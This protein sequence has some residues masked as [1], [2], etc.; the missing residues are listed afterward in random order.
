MCYN[1]CNRYIIPQKK[2]ERQYMT[3]IF[4]IRHGEAE[5][6][7]YRR[8]QG[9]GDVLLTRNG[10]RQASFL[11]PRFAE[12]PL[13][14]VYSS[15]LK[16]AMATA[17]AAGAGRGLAPIPEPRLREMGFGVWEGKTWGEINRLW[18]EEKRFFLTDPEK[19]TVPGMES[20]RAVAERYYA[21][22]AEIARRHEGGCAAAAGHGMAIRLLAADLR[23]VPFSRIQEV[24]LCSNTA[25]TTLV[26]DGETFRIE[27]YNDTSHLPE[28]PMAPIRA[29]PGRGEPGWDLWFTPYEVDTGRDRYVRCYQDAWRQA[30]GSLE[31]FQASACWL[32][33]LRYRQE[34]PAAVTE[35]RRGEDFAGVLTLDTR[36]GA[37]KG[38]GWIAFF[39]I[40]PEL[41]RHGC[42]MQ[43]L[44]EAV[45]RF[46]ALG[47]R[48]VRLSVAP[49]NPAR[50]FYE[51][52]GFVR[53]DTQPGALEPLWILELSL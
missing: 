34:D 16:R 35:A 22:L 21:A 15:D 6:N 46:R 52:A 11:T 29:V 40:V 9:Q 25:V 37:E 10:E 41:R 53:V 23:G 38:M 51:K 3:K 30:H 42:G 39:Y 13:E 33:A 17:R 36:R 45:E 18:P 14:A 2:G 7:L 27:D 4:L 5:G 12:V 19:L 48:A 1:L 50:A 43:L 28:P 26:W 20:A 31:G 49:G 24:P 8:C 44:G 47:R 32:S